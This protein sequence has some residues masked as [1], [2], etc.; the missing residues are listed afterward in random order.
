MSSRRAALL[1]AL[2]LLLP[3]LPA[4]AADELP[5]NKQEAPPEERPDTRPRPKPAAP[6]PFPEPAGGLAPGTVRVLLVPGQTFPLAV[7]GGSQVVCDDPAV[8]K[9]EFT[10][11]ALVLTAQG[12]G[13][14]LC[15]AR[16]AGAPRGLWYVV[17]EAK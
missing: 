14:T 7:P 1:L 17:V 10:E 16:L 11:G 2:P 6:K 13:A 4:A 5:G 12:L 8:V 3:A 9:A 15:G